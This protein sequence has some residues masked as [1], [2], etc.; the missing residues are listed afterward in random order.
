MKNS[1][2]MA[3]HKQPQLWHA[4]KRKK[5]VLLSIYKTEYTWKC[6]EIQ[7]VNITQDQTIGGFRAAFFCGFPSAMKPVTSMV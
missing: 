3:G 6:L 1:K 2:P 7:E 5:Y 4:V